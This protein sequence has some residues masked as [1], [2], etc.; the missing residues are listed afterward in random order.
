MYKTW[1]GQ[2]I[3]DDGRGQACHGAVAALLCFF[4]VPMVVLLTCR[5]GAVSSK[6]KEQTMETTDLGRETQRAQ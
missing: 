6:N 1:N 4:A 2:N 3:Q 5:K